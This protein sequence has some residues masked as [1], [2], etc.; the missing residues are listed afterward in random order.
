MGFPCK[1]DPEFHEREPG[2]R[3]TIMI[4][5]GSGSF[6]GLGKNI[7]QFLRAD[8]DVDVHLVNGRD[9]RKKAEMDRI[10]RSCDN[11]KT[12]VFNHGN[13]ETAE[14]SKILR[15]CDIVV[16]K[17]GANT[18]TEALSTGKV[19]ITTDRLAEQ[20]RQNAIFFGRKVP[21]FMIDKEHTL[22]D[23]IN[24]NLFDDEFFHDYL[25]KVSA[26]FPPG[27]KK[28]YADFIY[29]R[30]CGDTGSP[31]SGRRRRSDL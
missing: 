11:R 21:V 18:I 13:L 7:K 28:A 24:D 9:R 19:V 25:Q 20:E 14:Y 8:P 6:S 26:L 16:S 10:I 3:L 4:M 1:V 5:S 29:G 12:R 31:G 30:C 27:V 17:C 15:E 22:L 23:I 2:K